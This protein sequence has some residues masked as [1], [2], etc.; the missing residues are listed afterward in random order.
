MKNTIFTV[1]A[2]LFIAFSANAQEDE[3]KYGDTPEDQKKCKECISLYREYRDQKM[4]KDALP[5]WRCAFNTCPKS[6]LTLYIDGARFYGEFLDEI[7]EDESKVEERNAYIDTLM[8]VYDRRIEHFGEEGKVLALKGNDLFKYDPSRVE[9]ANAMFKRSIELEGMN[10]DAIPASRYYQTLYELYKL[11]KATKS[12]LLVEYMP[13]LE[14]LDYNIERLDDDV[15]R[16]RYEKAKNNLDAFFVKIADCDDI[17]RILGE[18]LAESPND[19]ELNK[20]TLAVMNSR[21][22]TENPLYLQVA[23]RV[24]KDKPS[25]DAA[26]SLGILKLKAKSYNEALKYFREA[27]ELCDDGCTR[28]NQ[29]YMRAGQSSVVLGNAASALNYASKMLQI[30]QRSGEAYILMGDAIAAKAKSCDD[31]KL[32]TVSAYWLAVDYYEKAKAVDPSVAKTANQ[33][34][35]SYAKQFPLKEELFFHQLD[36]GDKY[37][38]ACHN[39]EE[40]TVRARD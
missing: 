35:A 34:I 21:D 15:S 31:G 4:I 13:V 8:N 19:I 22:C 26:Y 25:H 36:T 39:N 3:S 17:Y 27:I 5:F 11:K 2:F 33:K 30:N 23:E 14:I 40:T 29:Y 12:D 1:L 9:E 6:A 32:G 37:K 20:K 38:V 18:R 10:C 7:F 24:Y 28:I 16:S